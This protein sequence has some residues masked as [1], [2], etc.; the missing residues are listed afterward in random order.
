M[1]RPHT[2]K[3][4][5]IIEKNNY[6]TKIVKNVNEIKQENLVKGSNFL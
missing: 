1:I 3:N 5:Y 2:K 6:Y 4:C